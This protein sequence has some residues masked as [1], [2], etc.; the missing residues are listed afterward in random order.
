MVRLLLKIYE[1][2]ADILFNEIINKKQESNLEL[3][4]NETYQNLDNIQQYIINRN[5]RHIEYIN[6][7]ENQIEASHIR[8]FNQEFYDE[9][10]SSKLI[11]KINTIKTTRSM[12]LKSQVA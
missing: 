9:L 3:E 2:L 10:K 5:L 12:A 1:K 8:G 11:C 4:A 6:Q 7:I